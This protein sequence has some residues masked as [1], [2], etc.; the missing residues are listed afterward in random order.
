MTAPRRS[1]W[2]PWTLRLG[3]TLGSLVAALVAAELALRAVYDE[4]EVNGNYWGRGAF[5]A[6]PGAGYRHAPGF[7]GRAVR[8]GVFDVAVEIDETGLRQV[9]LERQLARPRRLLLLGDSFPFGL[10]VAAEEA[11][12]ARLAERLEAAGVGVVNGAQTGY[13]VAQSAAWGRHLIDRFESDPV[14]L[15]PF[16]S[17]DVLDGWSGG[18]P[19]VDVVDGYRLS[20]RRRPR[21]AFF[22]ALRTRSY[23]WMRVACT[24]GNRWRQQE[25]RRYFRTTWERDPAAAPAP[26][27][28]AMLALRDL[29][30]K[31]GIGFAA[32]LIPYRKGPT[33]FD[34]PVRETLRREGVPLFDFSGRLSVEEH[35]L[36]GDGHWNAAGHAEAARILAPWLDPLP[37]VRDAG[38]SFAARD[39]EDGR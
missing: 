11:L 15:T 23:V 38:A 28:E 18:G 16:L 1:P 22:D 4:A 14:R 10:G 36:A 35:Y 29:C 37:S 33:P 2:R 20:H 25:W 24:L 34:E 17:N 9:D 39:T 32:V 27:L 7:R 8:P 13:D 3:L 19:R 31:R 21:G 30:A 5:V 6:F 26:A 12:P